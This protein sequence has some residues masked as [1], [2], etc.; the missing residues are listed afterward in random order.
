MKLQIKYNFLLFIVT[1]SL[2]SCKKFLDKKPDKTQVIITSLDDLQAILNGHFTMNQYGPTLTE[3]VADNYYISTTDYNSRALD[4]RQNYVWDKDAETINSWNFTYQNPV[5]YANVVLDGL[6]TITISAS[7]QQQYNAIKGTALFHRAFA[8]Q[9]L[10]DLFC[11]PYSSSAAT[12]HG[13]VLR[14]T[15]AIEDVSKR[16]TVQQTYD[17][18]IGDLKMAADLLPQTA[19]FPTVATRA[20]AYGVL[21]R[22]YLTMRDYANAGLYADKCLQEYSTLID[23]NTLVPVGSPPIKRFNAETI[24]FNTPTLVNFLATTRAKIDSTLYR[25]YNDN[26]L[27]KTVFFQANTGVNAGTFGFRGSYD[28]TSIPYQ[29]FDG[30]ATDEMYLIRAECFARAGNKD[31]AMA[32]LN[33]L[34]IKRWKNNGTWIP[35]TAVDA[36]DAK[37]K[38]L[39]ERRKELIY[40]CL[41]WSDIRRFNEE[42]AGISL[43]R[44]I[45]NIVYELPAGDPRFVLLIPQRVISL[46]NMPQNPR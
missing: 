2:F 20:A 18:I 9:R 10:S 42:G 22:T 14:L 44:I 39:A 29:P 32:D 34:M 25:S 21:A 31:A 38:V 6:K 23:Y 26:D 45:N 4:L 8:F 17:Q 11:R 27:R 24:Y 35:F 19:A 7:E 16:S 15:A 12:D 46:T 3:L 41:R 33:I 30:I 43:K 40:R 28:G 37:N 36:T 5:Y 1:L 13:I